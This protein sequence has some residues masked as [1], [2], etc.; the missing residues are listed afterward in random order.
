MTTAD[1][2]LQFL[3]YEM[4]DITVFLLHKC[5]CCI[6]PHTFNLCFLP[7]VTHTAL[8]YRVWNGWFLTGPR[9]D[10]SK[11]ADIFLS[12]PTLSSARNEQQTLCITDSVMDHVLC[13][14]VNSISIWRL[15]APSNMSHI[16]HWNTSLSHL[17]SLV[18]VWSQTHC[19]G[20]RVHY[21]ELQQCILKSCFLS[22]RVISVVLVCLCGRYSA[23][24]DEMEYVGSKF[25]NTA[26]FPLASVTNEDK[27][28]REDGRACLAL[29]QYCR[30]HVKRVVPG[31]NCVLYSDQQ[32]REQWQS[33]DA[34]YCL[35]V[36]Y[37]PA[38]TLEKV[39]SI[40]HMEHKAY[41]CNM[42]WTLIIG[43]I[44]YVWMDGEVIS[45]LAFSSWNL[46]HM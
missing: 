20:A 34:C 45:N 23:V 3:P 18:F 30:S 37:C 46:L 2:S 12:W 13:C 43:K 4:N 25:G 24:P 19:A 14:Q 35:Y 28:Q 33:K 40:K 39:L 29:C 16:G 36:W 21:A 22:I 5:T 8:I 38:F 26:L 27:N 17:G 10:A 42:F 6:L 7:A 9:V 11:Q 32:G 31:D 44:M 41:G 1:S 15:L